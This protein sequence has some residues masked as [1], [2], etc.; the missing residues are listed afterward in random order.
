MLAFKEVE[1]EVEVGVGRK[2]G[3]KEVAGGGE[4]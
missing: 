2:V 3:V 1:V 4:G